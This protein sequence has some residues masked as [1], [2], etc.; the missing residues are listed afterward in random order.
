MQ[1][2]Q[3]WVRQLPGDEFLAALPD[4]T[5]EDARMKVQVRKNC[6]GCH[7]ASYPLQHRFDEDGWFKILDLMKHVNVLGT[8]FGPDHKPTMN[9][10]FHQKRARR[11]SRARARAGRNLDEVQA[12]PAPVRR[13]GA[14]GVQGIRLPDGRRPHRRRTTA[15]TGRSARPPA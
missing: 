15:A 6:T 8:W 7:T 12:A 5:P 14:R 11:L 1:N 4:E 3:D 9:I 10:E 13:G 2:Q